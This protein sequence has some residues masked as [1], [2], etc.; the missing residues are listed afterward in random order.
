MSELVGVIVTFFPLLVVMWLANMA[1]ARRE[2]DEPGEGFRITAYVLV[3]LI[4]VSGLLIGLLLQLFGVLMETNPA[5]F[6][7]LPFPLP[8]DSFALLGSGLW[9]PSLIG[10]ILLLPPVRRLF[11]LFTRLDPD[12]PVHAVALSFSMLGKNE[13]MTIAPRMIAIAPARKA[14]SSPLRNDCFAASIIWSA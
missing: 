2:R 14:R 4:Y 8:V 1:Q 6:E 10:L 12:N 3:A 13:R 9:G 7:D 5:M 11:A